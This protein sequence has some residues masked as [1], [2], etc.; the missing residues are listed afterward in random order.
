[1]PSPVVVLLSFVTALI[2]S[3][4]IIYLI[5]R[6]FG[7]KEGI[8]T[9]LLA[10]LVGA[11]IYGIAY[12]FLPGLVAAILGGIVWLIALQKLYSIGWFKALIIAVVIW[13]VTSI[14][15]LFLPVL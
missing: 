5:A 1:M 14:V 6:M 4:I 13:I 9:A 15:G 7:E 12:F 10:A 11:I 8:T 2:I 3:T